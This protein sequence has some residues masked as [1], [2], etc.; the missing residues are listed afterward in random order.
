MFTFKFTIPVAIKT[1]LDSLDPENLDTF[2]LSKNDRKKLLKDLTENKKEYKLNEDEL[3]LIKNEFLQNIDSQKFIVESFELSIFDL[4]KQI[5]EV[6]ITFE[7]DPD[8]QE[9]EEDFETNEDYIYSILTGFNCENT[10]DDYAFKYNTRMSYIETFK[11]L[12]A[13]DKPTISLKIKK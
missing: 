12:I 2:G 7:F 6:T 10:E 4:E 13:L 11:I 3:K 9:L 5:L 8:F 1:N